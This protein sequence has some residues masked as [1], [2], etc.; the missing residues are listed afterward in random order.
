LLISEIPITNIS[1]KTVVQGRKDAMEIIMGR[2]NRLLVICGPCSL[3]DPVTALE[4][5]SRLKK[6]SDKLSDD[7]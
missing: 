2:S 4:Y 7:L 5:A 6:L 3:H 1:L